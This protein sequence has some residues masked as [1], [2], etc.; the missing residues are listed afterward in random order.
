[1]TYSTVEIW[2]V[3]ILIGIGTFL[4]RFS[5]LGIIGNRKMPSWILRHLRYTPVSVLP[6]L[7]APMV[8]WPQ[9]TDGA[10]DTPRMVAAIVTCALGYWT[11]NV[12]LSIIGGAS[13]L[14]AMLYF[15][16]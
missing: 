8:V 16:G 15:V 12:I 13:A 3:I 1:M 10:L 6:A 4:I 7:V 9:A 2:G 14:Y 11:K 5:F